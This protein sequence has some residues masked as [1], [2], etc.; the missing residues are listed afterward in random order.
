MNK[1]WKNYDKDG[2]GELDKKECEKLLK[3]MAKV[4]RDFSLL[5]NCEKVFNMLD[6]DGNGSLSK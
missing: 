1:I 6:M 3:D 2:S 5:N 4:C